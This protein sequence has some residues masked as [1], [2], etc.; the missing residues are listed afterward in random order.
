MSRP[1]AIIVEDN[2]DLADI[3]SV[4]LRG[5]GFDTEI[6]RD[7]RAAIERLSGSVPMVIVLDMH[8]PFV[9]GPEILKEI[10]ANERFAKVAV[11]VATADAQT[12]DGLQG[13]ADLVLLK[14]VSVDQLRELAKRML[15]RS[16]AA[17]TPAEPAP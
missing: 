10:R 12:A 15:L 17:A 2:P 1:L 9:G 6:I 8:L 11:I 4:S 7:G 14:P 16:N 3:F 5:G 13:K